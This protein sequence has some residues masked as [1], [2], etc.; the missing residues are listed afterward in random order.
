MSAKSLARSSTTL[1]NISRADAAAL[2]LSSEAVLASLA[3][4]RATLSSPTS[5][6]LR[7]WSAE[8]DSLA[9]A[10]ADSAATSAF[11][12]SLDSFSA[13]L[14]ALTSSTLT[15]RK[16]AL[17]A[18]A[19]VAASAPATARFSAAAS[20]ADAAFFAALSSPVS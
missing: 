8:D 11:C 17:S 10:V 15:S 12:E 14:S 18:A 13:S 2:A 4:L 5:F 3:D 16:R 9:L 19:S 7:S 1:V 20:A 6:E